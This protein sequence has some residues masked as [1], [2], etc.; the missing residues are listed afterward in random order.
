LK[1]GQDEKPL[2]SSVGEQE[3]N[4]TLAIWSSRYLR[5]IQQIAASHKGGDQLFRLANLNEFDPEAPRS[6]HEHL[7]S[8]VIG[9]DTSP[10][11]V[12]TNSLDT[13]KNQLADQA[14]NGQLGIY[15]L[16]HALFA[17]L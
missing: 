2:V 10:E 6:Y 7:H 11:S 13:V 16:S 4:K 12:I 5:W 1:N 17:L 3:L 15:G 14:Q 8:L 9:D